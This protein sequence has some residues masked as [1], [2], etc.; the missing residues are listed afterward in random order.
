MQDFR[1]LKVWQRAHALTLSIYRETRNFPRE[2][3][4]GLTSQIRRAA[5]SIAANLAEG[6]CRPTDRDFGRFVSIALGSA[7]ETDYFLLLAHDL[8]IL[9][10]PRYKLLVQETDELKK[11]LATLYARLQTDS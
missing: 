1:D 10:A 5:A 6:R 9:E 8:G 4:Y 11:M 7:A 2:E 3:L